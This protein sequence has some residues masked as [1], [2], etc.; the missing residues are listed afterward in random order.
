[1]ILLSSTGNSIFQFFTVILIF[2]LVLIVTIY[3]TRWMGKYQKNTFS[4]KN[5]EVCEAV[6]ISNSKVIAVVRTGKSRYVVVGVGKDEVNFL[7]ELSDDDII[8]YEDDSDSYH[9]AGFS[10]TLKNLLEKNEDHHE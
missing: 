2:V 3:T 4:K 6:R 7:T 10:A 1:M 8:P 5:L 9:K